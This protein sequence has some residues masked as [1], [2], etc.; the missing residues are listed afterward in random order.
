MPKERENFI[1]LKKMLSYAQMPIVL[2]VSLGNV[3][4]SRGW[5]II[6]KGNALPMLHGTLLLIRQQGLRSVERRAKD[7]NLVSG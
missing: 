3:L 4:V 7:P 1:F 6:I 5:Q 2:W